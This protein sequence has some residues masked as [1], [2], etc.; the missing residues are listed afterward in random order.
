MR[1]M[2]LRFNNL[3]K[4]GF[5]LASLFWLVS[6]GAAFSMENNSAKDTWQVGYWVWQTHKPLAQQPQDMGTSAIM[7]VE[8]GELSRKEKDVCTPEIRM[9]WP[10]RVPKAETYIAVWRYD[11]PV[12]PDAMIV[13]D[14]VEQ[15]NTMK[16][17]AYSRGDRIIGLQIDFDCPTARLKEYAGLLKALKEQL[18]AGDLLSITALLGWFQPGSAFAKVARHIDEFVPQFYDINP[19]HLG[20]DNGGIGQKLDPSYWGPLFNTYKKPYR[21]GISSFGR[22]LRV[23]AKKNNKGSKQKCGPVEI[24]NDNPLESINRYQLAFMNESGSSAGERIVRYKITASRDECR[25]Q[26]SGTVKMI[27]P[28]TASVLAVYNGAR[29][30]GRL[31]KGVVF[32]RWPLDNEAMVL[33]AT[34]LNGMISGHKSVDSVHVEAVDG[35][36]A[37]VACSD[38]YLTLS[39]RFPAKSRTVRVRSTKPLEYF[40]PEKQVTSRMGRQQEIVITI[41]ANAGV[42]RIFL[43]RAVTLD[44]SVYSAELEEK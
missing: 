28:T 8:A 24:L 3:S 35:L 9:K 38:L 12:P 13:H 22:I 20:K 31:C 40:L 5:V 36:C 17:E 1:F 15:F 2:L 34:E 10:G 19:E 29:N 30:L 4:T 21:I 41:P 14:L 26:V 44:T 16:R 25:E 39:E 43:G 32:F 23:D 37:A 11:A 42:P 33:S 27:I 18:G 7:Y 6:A